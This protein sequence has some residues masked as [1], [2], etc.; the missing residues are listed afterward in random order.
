LKLSPGGKQ[1]EVW[2]S[3]SSLQPAP[4]GTG[5]DGIAFGSDGNQYVNRFDA[6]DLY[7]IDVKGGKAGK[8][9]KLNPS[10]KLELTDGIR[11]LGQGVF[12]LI[13]GAG[14]LDTMTIKGDNA[15]IATLKD[16][17]V[18][19][20]GVTPVGDIAWVSEGQLDYLF[21]PARHGQKPR[22]PFKLFAVPLP[23]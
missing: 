5:L 23:K 6:A 3:D 11:P 20:T 15:L 22:L 16:G 18:T 1:L 17:Y 4:N 10:R 7:R 9:T 12:L 2:Y 21:D 19:P 8:L 13:E 14:R